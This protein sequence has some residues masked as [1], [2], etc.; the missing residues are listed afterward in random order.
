VLR[1]A[2]SAPVQDAMG[3]RAELVRLA[4]EARA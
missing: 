2:W 1:I 3:V 4:R